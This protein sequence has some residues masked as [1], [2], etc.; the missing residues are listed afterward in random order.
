MPTD[1][2]SALSEMRAGYGRQTTRVVDD[3]TDE[4]TSPTLW[5]RPARELLLFLR[6]A[7]VTSPE[8]AVLLGDLRAALEDVEIPERYR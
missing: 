3:V 7:K 2:R 4:P 5:E 6:G 1:L 8:S